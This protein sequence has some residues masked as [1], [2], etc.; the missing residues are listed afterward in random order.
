LEDVLL[1][2][3]LL[4]KIASINSTAAD[5]AGYTIFYLT[6]EAKQTLPNR[7]KRSMSTL[8]DLMVST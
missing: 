1:S 8:F 5:K 3:S 7:K 6:E 2:L 4:P